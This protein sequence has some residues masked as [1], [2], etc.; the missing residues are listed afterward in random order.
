MKYLVTGAAGFIGSNI[1]RRLLKDNYAVRGFDNFST[2]KRK[3]LVDLHGKDNFELIK[4]DLRNPEEIKEAVKDIDVI[5][6]QAAVPSVQR[7]V[8]NP[9]LV[10]DSNINGTLNLL[11]AAREEGV[12]KVVYASSSSIYG[13][14]K[15]LPK[16]EDMPAEPISPYALSKYTGERYCQIFSEIYNLPTICLRYFNVFGPYQD[17]DSEYSAAIPKFINRILKDKQPVIFGDGE[18]SRDFTYVA[19][20]V[21]AN[22]LAANS[23]VMGEVINIASGERITI[24]EVVHILNKILNKKTEPVYKKSRVGEVKHSLADISKAREKIGYLPKF[25]FIEGLRKTV[26]WYQTGKKQIS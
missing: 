16:A 7:S 1:S 14:N 11:I 15:K 26:E 12:K 21:E 24:N 9:V 17:P 5:F 23:K 25:K 10:N 8:E 3:N 6:H 19:N 20:V 2:G 22:I 13:F 4:G 18:Q